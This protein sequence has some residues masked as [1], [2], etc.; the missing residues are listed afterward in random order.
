MSN[1]TVLFLLI[2]YYVLNGLW[3]VLQVG[4]YVEITPAGAVA[5]LIFYALIVWGIL[6]VAT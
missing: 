3:T 1:N 2:G 4:E 6:H 5:T